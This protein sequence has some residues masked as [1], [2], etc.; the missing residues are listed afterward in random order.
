MAE[1]YSTAPLHHKHHAV[2]GA[3]LHHNLPLVLNWLQGRRLPDSRRS[4]KRRHP[5]PSI[6]APD[7]WLWLLDQIPLQGRRLVDGRAPAAGVIRAI[8]GYAHVQGFLAKL[9]SNACWITGG[10]SGTGVWS[11]TLYSL[12]AAVPEGF[13]VYQWVLAT[14]GVAPDAAPGHAG[15]SRD[16]Y[17]D[18]LIPRA[19][20]HATAADVKLYLREVGFRGPSPAGMDWPQRSPLFTC[21]L[22]HAHWV[23]AACATPRLDVY[24]VLLQ[25]LLLRPDTCRSRDQLQPPPQ[26]EDWWRL[27]QEPG[28]HADRDL[29]PRLEC[30][31]AAGT[32]LSRLAALC[33][34]D[35]AFPHL[36]VDRRAT[37]AA[38]PRQ[39]PDGGVLCHVAALLAAPTL[40]IN[41]R[42]ALLHPAWWELLPEGGKFPPGTAGAALP[43]LALPDERFSMETARAAFAGVAALAY[44]LRAARPEARKRGVAYLVRCLGP[45]LGL[46][47]LPA[48]TLSRIAAAAAL[49]QW[50][51]AAPLEQLFGAPFFQE[52]LARSPILG[53]RAPVDHYRSFPVRVRL[54]TRGVVH[55]AQAALLAL[56]EVSGPDRA[57]EF[58]EAAGRALVGDKGSA[59]RAGLTRLLSTRNLLATRVRRLRRAVRQRWSDGPAG[60]VMQELE[61]APA[62]SGAE[63]L[64]PRGGA[65]AA[66]LA[67]AWAFR[68]ADEGLFPPP[69]AHCNPEELAWFAT[70]P[71]QTLLTVKADGVFYE[72][73]F[74]P[75]AHPPVPGAWSA[76][77]IQAE[78]VPLP[79][80]GFSG[81]SST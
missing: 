70:H 10:D 38:D 72:G 32:P 71:A 49:K 81:L 74:P 24:K 60:K 16:V 6:E 79:G 31:V 75:G 59:L 73:G 18:I 78:Q 67:A 44:E 42:R 28:R 77:T 27:L 7:E 37:S 40:A 19:V 8:L 61:L 23:A 46:E 26:A 52:M 30:L 50:P 43:A 63:G 25:R 76:C 45:W 13:P 65:Q 20:R 2:L 53:A 1:Y 33:W 22:G 29:Q 54:R 15:P 80:G 51:A 39:E 14:T 12:L 11:V 68:C 58:L 55:D 64:L 69:P 36:R 3:L 35:G 5:L 4:Q 56:A 47:R 21:E 41:K 57:G 62:P 66:T 9:A 34:A 17:Y 48:A